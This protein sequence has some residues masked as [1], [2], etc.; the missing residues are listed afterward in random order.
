MVMERVPGQKAYE[1]RCNS[2]GWSKV[3]VTSVMERCLPS[4]L[5]NDKKNNVCQ[6]CGGKLERK[7]DVLIRF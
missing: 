1:L 4:F 7:D 3:V 5:S 6:K 2:C